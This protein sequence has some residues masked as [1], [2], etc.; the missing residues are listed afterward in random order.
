MAVE[1]RV[2]ELNLAGLVLLLVVA[3]VAILEGHDEEVADLSQSLF[4]DERLDLVWTHDEG[5]D[6]MAVRRH[7]ECMVSL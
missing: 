5:D 2:Y 7:A 4:M 3:D 6:A 1:D